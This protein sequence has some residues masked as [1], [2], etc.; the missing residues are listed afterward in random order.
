MMARAW[1]ESARGLASGEDGAPAQAERTVRRVTSLG[2]GAAGEESM[3]ESAAAVA[4]R[5]PSRAGRAMAEVHETTSRGG[6][7]RL[8]F[9]VARRA[10]RGRLRDGV[11]ATAAM[12]EKL[13]AGTVNVEVEPDQA[14][15]PAVVVDYR[16][17]EECFRSFPV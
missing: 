10:G 14:L 6:V 15:Q 11:A 2:A 12:A 7:Q 13:S 17:T 5:S 8:G 1:S 3:A 4:G 9:W 16:S